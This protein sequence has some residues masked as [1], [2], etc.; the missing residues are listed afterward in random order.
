M[1]L[2]LP[3]LAAAVL[4]AIVLPADAAAPLTPARPLPGDSHWLEPPPEVVSPASAKARPERHIERRKRYARHRRDYRRHRH[5]RFAR[6]HYPRRYRYV[7]A[8][9]GGYR[10][11]PFAYIGLGR[12]EASSGGP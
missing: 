10:G 11:D 3:G 2:L 9:G 7:G 1:K 5:F 8:Y 4:L 12:L 6:R